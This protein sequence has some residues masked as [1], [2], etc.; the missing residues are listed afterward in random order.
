VKTPRIIDR[1]PVPIVAS[2]EA[3]RLWCCKVSDVLVECFPELQR[4][5]V[6]ADALY[7]SV[8]L[9]CYAIPAKV[10][11]KS[12]DEITIYDILYQS[13]DVLGIPGLVNLQRKSRQ[14]YR[15]KIQLCSAFQVALE[16]RG[17]LY[18][19]WCYSLGIDSRPLR[20]WMALGTHVPIEYER[21][22]KEWIVLCSPWPISEDTLA[23]FKQIWMYI[24]GRE[25]DYEVD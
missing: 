25:V 17:V 6:Y 16:S 11:N 20:Y 22:I 14:N 18:T 13:I 3:L 2:D 1:I 19:E 10:F 9:T 4:A 5:T 7:A 8:V 23:Y 24:P 15:F 21:V 12:L